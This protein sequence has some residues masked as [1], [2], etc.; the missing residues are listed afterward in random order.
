MKMPHQP[1]SHPIDEVNAK[2][3]VARLFSRS[4]KK[5]SKIQ[6]LGLTL[7]M[8]DL[9]TLEGKDSP[10]KVKQLCYKAAHLYDQF[11]GLPNVAAICVYPTM[12]P[13]AKEALS[14]TSIQIASVATSFPSGMADLESKLNEVRS[15]VDAGANEVDMVISRGRFLCGDYAYVSDE[16]AKMKEACGSAYLKVILETGELFTLD[17]V[18][19]AS[20]LA[21]EAGADFIKTS[22]GKVAPAATPS[23]VLTMLEAIRDFQ[24]KKGKKI[25]MKP[26]GGIGSAKQAIQYLVMVN[27]TLGSDWLSPDLFRFGASSLANDVIMQIVKQDTGNYQSKDYFSLD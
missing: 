4:I 5:E 6:A 17:N 16:I 27:E 25:G 11:P 15:V 20:D 10:G 14:G 2:E 26:A 19:L 3:R 18:R 24:T 22:T 7:S 9:T 13:I 12:V 1:Y 8:I 21:M 23:V